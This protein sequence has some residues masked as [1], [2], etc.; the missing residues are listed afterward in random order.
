MAGPTT[1]DWGDGSPVETGPEKGTASHAYATDGTKTIKVCDAA[2]PTVCTTTEVTIPFPPTATPTVTAAADPADTTGRTAAITLANFP[3]NG[4]VNV[5]WG[6]GAAAQT[7][8]AGTT[9]ATH[10]YAA[11]VDGAQTIT[12]TSATD[13]TKTASTTF[14]PTPPAAAPAATATPDAADS[15]TASLAWTGFPAATTSVSVNWGDGTAAQTGLATAGGAGTG[16]HTY[17]A[18]AGGTEQTI[19]VTSEQDTTQTATATFTPTA[20]APAPA[21]TAAAD[22]ADT[23]GHT[24]TLTLANF[25]ADSAVSVNWGDGSAAE[26]IAAGTTTGSHVYAAGVTTEQTITATSVGDASKT[27]TTTFTPG[28]GAGLRAARKK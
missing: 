9:T 6:D 26:E 17:A 12:A 8:P 24:T 20:P 7:V 25:P 3:P 22:A 21:A 16:T 1:I 11:G 23:T 15:M 14:T 5:N 13:T 10:A 2:A 18:G 28:G 4:A 27:A 19:T